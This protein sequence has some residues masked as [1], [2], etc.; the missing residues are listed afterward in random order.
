L[1]NTRGRRERRRYE[2]RMEREKKDRRK[3]GRREGI[4]VRKNKNLRE[5]RGGGER[6][7]WKDEERKLGGERRK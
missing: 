3:G 5:G 7:T 2:K 4:C 1:R 6:W